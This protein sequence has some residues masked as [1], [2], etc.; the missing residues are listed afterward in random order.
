MWRPGGESRPVVATEQE[1]G[2][3]A[4]GMS[5]AVEDGVGQ[6]LG[7]H[8]DFMPSLTEATGELYAVEQSD[9]I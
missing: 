9:L 8:V 6:G 4:G 7:D 3:R 5:L 2:Q 1:E